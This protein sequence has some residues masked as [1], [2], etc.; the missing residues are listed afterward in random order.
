M[1][2][3]MVAVGRRPPRWV[4][5]GMEDFARRLP[6]HLRLRLVEV[7]P[8]AAR[9]SGDR[10][11]ARAEEANGLLAGAGDAIIVA[12]DEAGEA[13]RSR[14]LARRLEGWLQ[15]GQDV[16]FLMGGADGLDP[17]CHAAA[18]HCWSLSALTL[19]HL[20]VRVVL[21]EQL[22]RAWTLL[23]GHPYHRE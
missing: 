8:G 18:R 3:R 17:R 20:L 1:E 22:Y 13:W 2:L 5:E 9:R 14:D 7:P 6:R 10:E 16:A 15:E 21:A 4:S 19:P 11:R 23:E 12:L